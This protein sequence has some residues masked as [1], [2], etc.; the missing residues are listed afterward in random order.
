MRSIEIEQESA[1][2]E[3]LEY[4]IAYDLLEGPALGI[5]KQVLSKGTESLTEKQEY[6]YQRFVADKYFSLECDRCSTP[7]PTCEVVYALTEG[8][9]LCAWCRH[10]KAKYY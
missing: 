9:D 2:G 10:M 8:D 1:E 4:L 7:M 5:A 6:I 3:V